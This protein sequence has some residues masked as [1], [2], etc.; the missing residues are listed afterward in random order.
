MAYVAPL[1]DMMFNIRHLARI[2]EI[3][4]MPGFEDAGLETAQAVLEE[5]AR[6]NQDVIAPLNEAGDRNPSSWKDGVVTTTPGF[7]DAFRQFA[8]GGWQGLQHPTHFGGQGLP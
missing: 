2:D 4:Q 5:S 7:K 3:A 1:K 8:A 6:F